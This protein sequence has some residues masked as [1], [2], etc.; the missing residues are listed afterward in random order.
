MM[1]HYSEAIVRLHGWPI[2]CM[3]L[4]TVCSFR[5]NLLLAVTIHDTRNVLLAATLVSNYFYWT[6]SKRRQNRFRI[7]R[8]MLLLLIVSVLLL[9]ADSIAFTADNTL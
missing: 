2:V 3:C 8:A 5:T 4:R 7:H 9:L 1:I 6:V